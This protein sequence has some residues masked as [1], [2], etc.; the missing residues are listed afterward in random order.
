MRPVW[1]VR[2][3]DANRERDAVLFDKLIEKRMVVN[4]F[5]RMKRSFQFPST[6]LLSAENKN[7]Q[8]TDASP[9]N[10]VERC[11]VTSIVSVP[12]DEAEEADDDADN[13]ADNEAMSEVDSEIDPD[14]EGN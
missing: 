1:T 2:N 11:L 10:E 13:E 6:E 7:A 5:E 14:D 12:H 4:A 8:L 3:A 9:I